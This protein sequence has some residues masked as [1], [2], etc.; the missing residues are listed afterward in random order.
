MSIPF[1]YSEKIP[2]NIREIFMWLC[3]DVVSLQQKW[4][5]YLEL[6]SNEENTQLLS[7]LAV[8][9]FNL[10]FETTQ[11]EITMAICRLS[12]PVK[13]MGQENLSLAILEKKCAEMEGFEKLFTE[14]Y[15]LCE[16]VRHVRN[17]RVGHR[18]LNAT[19]RPLVNPL[20]GISRESID[21]ILDSVTSI[22]NQVMQYYDD[23]ALYFH[24]GGSGGA[25]TLIFW[26]KE[27][28]KIRDRI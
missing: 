6:F 28:R 27:G 5:F 26:L 13:S 3:Q 8:A 7:E 23:S 17:K 16:P 21:R 14:F 4:D 25:D 12:D 24:V 19:N 15:E 9:S 2:E 18:D 22:L 11:N 10:I 20:P 1:G